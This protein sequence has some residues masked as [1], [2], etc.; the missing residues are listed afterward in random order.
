MTDSTQTTQQSQQSQTSPWAPAQGLLTNLIGSYG[1]QST[2]V[3]PGQSSAINNLTSSTSN[4]PDFTGSATNS[5]NNLLNSSNAGQVGLLQ[6]ANNQLQTN[7]GATADPNNAINPL[8]DPGISDALAAVNKGVTNSVKSVYAGSGRDPS[9]A[10]SFAGSLASGLA[11]GEAPIITSQYNTDK[12]N[13][14][15][16]A[17]TLFSGANTT[18]SGI[19]NLNSSALQNQL[20][21]LGAAG[22][23]P[24]IAGQNANAQ[25]GAANT[26]YSLP[27]ANLAALLSPSTA[28]AGLGGQS[29]GSGTSTQ[30]SSPSFLSSLGTML[31]DGGK[32]ASGLGAL[33][34]L[35][36]ERLKTDVEKV[37]KLDSGPNIYNFRFKG[38]PKMHTGLIAQNV[39]KHIPAAVHT[40]PSGIKAVDYGHAVKGSPVGHLRSA[41]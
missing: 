6:N 30:T 4:L 28:I 14:M 26:A 9:G 16:A 39:E 2:A 35:S 13:Q 41:A 22:T 1:N 8:T 33:L 17:N 31:S 7:L 37:G 5:V 25:L 36:D 38:S 12:A 3:T 32:G 27:Y 20:A 10:G 19:S 23:V 40:M 29:T 18:A 11:Q 34:A 24:T 15:N 21:G